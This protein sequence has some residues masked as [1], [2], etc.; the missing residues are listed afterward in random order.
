M[1]QAVLRVG[2]K[3]VE[4]VQQRGKRLT[5][6]EYL[7]YDDCSI[8]AIASTIFPELQLTVEQILNAGESNVGDAIS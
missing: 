8:R 1:K 7:K 6:E 2:R 4:R 5:L 3:P